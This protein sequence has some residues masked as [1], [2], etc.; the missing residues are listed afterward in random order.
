MANTSTNVVAGVPLVTGGVLIGPTDAT[1]PDDATTAVDPGFVAAGYVS[2]DGLTETNGRTTDKIREWGGATVKVVQTEYTVTYQ[3]TFIESLNSDVLAA[4]YG[5]G[6][7]TTTAATSSTGTLQ[8][9]AVNKA[10]LPHK[11]FVFEMKD[12]NARIRIVVPNGQVTEVG[13]ITY[14]NGSAVGYQVTIEA[15]E[16][17]SGNNAY[18][19]LDDGVF[20]A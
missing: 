8:T 14:N 10:T 15:F 9:V 2:S 18:K 4:V 20:S 12:G 19:Y 16:D 13:D 5:D 3:L 7:I 1:L 17:A 11:A 6:N